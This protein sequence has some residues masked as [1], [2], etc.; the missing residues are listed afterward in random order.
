MARLQIRSDANALINEIPLPDA[1]IPRIRTVFGGVTN[2]ETA[3]AVLT[4]I[5]SQVR[6][7]V[8]ESQV[9]SARQSQIGIVEAAGT[10]ARESFESEWPQI[11]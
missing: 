3:L 8:R 2:P 9:A 10:A 11:D 5:L 1:A 4:W 7:Y 6:A